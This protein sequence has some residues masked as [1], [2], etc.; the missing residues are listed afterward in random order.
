MNAGVRMGW[1]WLG[2]VLVGCVENSRTRVVD[3]SIP[4]TQ[5]ARQRLV[6][7][8]RYVSK[9]PAT[10]ATAKR[11]LAV[12]HKLI[13][14]N[15]ELGMRPL[16]LT[17]GVPHPEIFHR[18]G[19]LENYQIVI[20]EGLVNRCKDDAQ[21]AAVLSLELAKIATE[22]QA[23][24]DPVTPLRERRPLESMGADRGGLFGQPDG[25]QQMEA[26]HAEAA[27]RKPRP[28]PAPPETLAKR[29][30]DK[31]H[32]NPNAL[33][34]VAGLLRQAEDHSTVEQHLSKVG[35][36]TIVPTAKLAAPIATTPPGEQPI[37]VSRKDK[38][39]Q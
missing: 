26:A 34:E 17:V 7:G 13:L 33:T 6:Q 23:M 36:P 5:V 22:R 1:L 11:V 32:F 21:L 3:G 38:S 30:L 28:A 25:T 4:S 10:E 12:G 14:A 16:F 19:G 18:G 2:L 39:G 8:Q 20:S 9:A 15:P 24:S 29:Y 37:A 31:A 35:Q 27:R